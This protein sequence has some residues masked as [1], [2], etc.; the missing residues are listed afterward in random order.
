MSFKQILSPDKSKFVKDLDL[1]MPITKSWSRFN[2]N[3]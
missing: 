1:I 3:K 2:E